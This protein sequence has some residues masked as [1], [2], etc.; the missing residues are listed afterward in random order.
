VPCSLGGSGFFGT[1][2]VSAELGPDCPEASEAGSDLPEPQPAT[3]TQATNA[4]EVPARITRLVLRLP[5][6]GDKCLAGTLN[7]ETSARQSSG[8]TAKGR[9]IGV[10]VFTESPHSSSPSSPFSQRRFSEQS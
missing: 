7:E 1:V 10:C 4:A 3:R 8:D 2:V 9:S 6:S 5:G